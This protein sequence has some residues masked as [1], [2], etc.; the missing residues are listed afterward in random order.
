MTDGETKPEEKIVEAPAA[1]KEG[2]DETV[3]V[4][5]SKGAM[6]DPKSLMM[7]MVGGGKKE[8]IPEVEQMGVITLETLN[9]HDCDNP[10]RRLMCLFGEVY[11]VSSAIDKYGP[12]GSYKEFAGHDIT[13]TL[14]AGQMGDKW[15]DKFIKFDPAWK[16]GAEKWV[17][18]YA[19]KYPKCGRLDKWENEDPDSWPEPTPE[20]TEALNASCIIL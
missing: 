1:N 8:D 9:A 18:Y 2:G 4:D 19:G 11:D 7:G 13:L 20:E 12:D 10:D 6:P 14:G 17:D 15:L 16:E 5:R 3:D